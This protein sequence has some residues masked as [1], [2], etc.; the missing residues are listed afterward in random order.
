MSKSQKGHSFRGKRN[1]TMTKQAKENIR[2]G[3]NEK[4]YSEEYALKLSK[5]K[6]G[7]KN[8]QVKL[9]VE[10]VLAIRKLYESN[11]WTQQALADR[12]EVKRTTI[13]DIVNRRTWKHI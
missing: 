11:D 3:I 2:N 5:N 12:Y 8:P 4:R 10:Q 1:Y 9:S 6:L 13:A 7:S